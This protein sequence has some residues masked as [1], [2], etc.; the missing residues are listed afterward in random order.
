ME[1]LDWLSGAIT[2]FGLALFDVKKVV[3]WCTEDL[4][5][6]E[7]AVRT[8]AVGVLAA[9]HCQVAQ[10]PSSGCLYC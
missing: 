4:T 1:V 3:A 6:R 10:S 7:A 8:A 2:D 5:S 9:A